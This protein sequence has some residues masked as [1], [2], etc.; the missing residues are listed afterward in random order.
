MQVHCNLFT[1]YLLD[2]KTNWLSLLKIKW[3]KLYIIIILIC[4]ILNCLVSE[5]WL[6]TLANYDWVCVS[7]S[8]SSVV[9]WTSFFELF[10]F[11]KKHGPSF[12]VFFEFTYLNISL[13]SFLYIESIESPSK[14]YLTASY[15]AFIYI[16][17]IYYF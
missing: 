7:Y 11:P 15:K 2:H 4:V 13:H 9:M 8:E 5:W 10:F 6:T 12:F 17:S 3:M 14:G 16:A 1:I